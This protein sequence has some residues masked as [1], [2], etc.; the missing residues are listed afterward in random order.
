MYRLNNDLVHPRVLEA[1]NFGVEE[2]LWRT[3]PLRTNLGVVSSYLPAG[4][5]TDLP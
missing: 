4:H 2:N 5:A 1:D 3:E